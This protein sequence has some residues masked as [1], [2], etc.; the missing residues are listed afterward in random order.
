MFVTTKYEFDLLNSFV[1]QG[2]E[3]FL[4]RF[5]PQLVDVPIQFTIIIIIIIV[6]ANIVVVAVF[7]FKQVKGR[8]NSIILV[9][10]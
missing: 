2:A 6:I 8:A 4:K 1:R 10:L 5:L 9:T 7:F 3:Q